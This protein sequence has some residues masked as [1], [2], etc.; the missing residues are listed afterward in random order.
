MKTLLKI[1]VT[2]FILLVIFALSGLFLPKNVKIESVK[3]IQAPIEI[4]FDQVNKLENW[5]NWSPWLEKDSTMKLSYQGP[6]AGKGAVYI[7][8]GEDSGN[9]S[10]E[11]TG[12]E[13]N[14]RIE[15]YINFNGQSNANG[16][17]TFEEI[18]GTTRIK[19]AF[20]NNDAKYAERYFLAFFKKNIKRM[21]E[22]GLNNIEEVSKKLKKSRIGSI[23]VED[24][25]ERHALII[26]DSADFEGIGSKMGEM[27]GLLM[28]KME[29]MNL[30]V[31]GAP[32]AIYHN[33]DPEGKTHFACGLPISKKVYARKPV[34]YLRLKETRV[35]SVVHY[36]EY[37]TEKAHR[38]IDQFVNEN[39]L[40]ITGAPWEEYL[41]D[42]MSETDT[43]KW[44]TKVYYPILSSL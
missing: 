13:S 11:I 34:E 24:L 25:E 31:V 19:W 32:F 28:K 29:Q 15:T 41:T 21:L 23:T 26:Q 16:E 20:I 44:Q 38:A 22:S 10:L 33:W 5:E 9:G 1:L 7:W 14:A 17:W 4:V 40:V 3:D 37:N 18:N 8:S 6:A 42:P 43:S 27:Y 35:V 12:S 2:I 30:E 36:G 39:Q